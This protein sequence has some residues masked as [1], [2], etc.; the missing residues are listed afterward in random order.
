V[1]SRGRSFAFLIISPPRGIG[2]TF[3]TTAILRPMRGSACTDAVA[4]QPV[5]GTIPHGKTG[6][7]SSGPAL[8][9]PHARAE[10]QAKAA[11]PRDSTQQVAGEP[12]PGRA[13]MSALS[14]LW[15]MRSV[16]ARNSHPYE[17]HQDRGLH[18]TDESRAPYVTRR[19][20]GDRRWARGAP[21]E[22]ALPM[23]A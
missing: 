17:G 11:A 16:L 7:R 19:W 6:V 2:P 15:F 4:C 10:R 3:G 13:R 8:A 23:V 21:L 12:R 22:A 18:R 20:A 5:F 14:C 9:R 1:A